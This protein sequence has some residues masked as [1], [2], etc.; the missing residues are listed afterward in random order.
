[1]LYFN[2]L[3]EF[4]QTKDK[5]VLNK[6]EEYSFKL[7]PQLN[8]VV[9]EFEKES[10]QNTNDLKDRE[11]LILFGTLL[12]ILL[13]AIFIILPSIKKIETSETILQNLNETLEYKVKEKTKEQDEL[14]SIF[15]KG[16]TVLF[17]WN[18]DDKWSVNHVSSNVYQLLEYKDTDFYTNQISY[19]D[20]I[21][22]ED[23]EVVRQEVIEASKLFANDYFQHKPY[24]VV[25]K[26]G[27]IKWVLDSSIII[28]DKSNNII[29]YLGHII[30]ITD[31]KN[32]ED[33]LYKSEKM[34]SMGEMIGN[35]AHQWRQP[36]SAISTAST[37]IVMQKKY[38][39][40]DETNLLDT[41]NKI[42]DNAQ[43]LSKTIDDF[44]NFIKGDRTKKLY[45][46]KDDIDSFLHLIKGP[47]KSHNINIILNL[48]EDI[49]IDGYE[50][51]L[52]QCLINIF[53]NAKDILKE[54]ISTNEDRLIF[55][56]TSTNKDKAIVKIKDNGGG[57]PT[58][59]I[60]KVFEPYFTTKHQSQGTGLGLHMT[61]N[62]IVDGM[63]GTIEAHNLTY[64]YEG[65][66]YTGAEFKIILPL[67]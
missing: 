18:N 31:L 7:L 22:N 2:L 55:I 10:N 25:T 12:T 47:I 51:E 65:K 52:T 40:L 35:I 23:L 4:V 54:K 49:K 64:E 44:R 9:N 57:I 21:F 66:K 53:N 15:D 58:D 5:K 30:D 3:D 17:K 56:S 61:Y 42:N 1:K 36:L 48:Q 67:K 14:L 19:E 60:N 20:C 62:L 38:G 39:I 27:K 63:G 33:M 50:N 41:C 45:S 37:G 13:E 29:N 43:Y 59:I 8:Y 46:L 32:K 24:R 34:A 28:T 16:E 6:I 11:L 26:T